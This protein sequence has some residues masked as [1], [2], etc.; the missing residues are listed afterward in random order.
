[1]SLTSMSGAAAQDTTTI[2]L[3]EIS[4]LASRVPIVWHKQARM[5]SSLNAAAIGNSPSQS[6]NDLLK[7]S[8]SIDVR[9]RGPIGAQ[10]D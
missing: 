6:I 2:S 9:Q 7:Y 10:T 1:M 8:A 4:V 5:V 3:N